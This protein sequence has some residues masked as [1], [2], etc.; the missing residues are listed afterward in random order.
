LL[1][2]VEPLADFFGLQ[3]L[4]VEQLLI[5]FGGSLLIFVYVELEKLFLRSRQRRQQASVNSN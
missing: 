5:C 2:Y 1:L 3:A 4:S